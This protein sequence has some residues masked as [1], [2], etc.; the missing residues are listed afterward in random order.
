MTNSMSLSAEKDESQLF[1]NSP[2]RLPYDR[3]VRATGFMFDSTVYPC[4]VYTMD[5][6]SRDK[7]ASD[8]I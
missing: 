1:P 4:Y 5:V 3:V 7:G 6:T 2:I 8:A